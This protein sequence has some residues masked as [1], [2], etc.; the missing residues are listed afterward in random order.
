MPTN[1]V[2]DPVTGIFRWRP[3]ASQA[4]ATNTITVTAT[5]NGIPLSASQQFTVIVNPVTFEFVL[6]FG[7]T[8]VLAGQT[9]SIPSRCKPR[10][11]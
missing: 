9:S 10:L 7:Y 8:N 5:D 11:R 3:T 4:P 6:A 1:A 2:V